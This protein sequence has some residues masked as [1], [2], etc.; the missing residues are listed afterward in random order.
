MYPYY[1]PKL[2]ELKRDRPVV[3]NQLQQLNTQYHYPGGVTVANKAIPLPSGPA[4]DSTVSWK[5]KVIDF[6]RKRLIEQRAKDQKLGQDNVLAPFTISLSRD[7]EGRS[8]LLRVC[9]V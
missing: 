4:F 2:Q 3:S 6:Y 5:T 8:Y 7:A 1:H 9:L